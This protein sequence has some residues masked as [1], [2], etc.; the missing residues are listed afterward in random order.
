MSKPGGLAQKLMEKTTNKTMSKPGSLTAAA[1]QTI[2]PGSFASTLAKSGL[3]LLRGHT[4][5]L[6]INM[7]LLCNQMCRHCHLEAGPGRSETMDAKT[8]AD[9]IGFAGGGGFQTIDITG[10]APELNSNLT[11]L[12]ER[13]ATLAPRIML[14]CN[15][16]ALTD[17]RRHLL[18][19]C[20]EYKV[21]L[22]A[23]FPSLN[24]GQADSQRGAGTWQRSIAAL[25][26]LNA[27]GYGE[28]GSGLELDIV[29]NPAGAF[30][31]S[32]Q[33]A[34]EKKFRRDLGA[35]WGI[36]FNH[37]YTFGNVPLGRFRKWLTE[38]GNFEA[39]MRRLTECFNPC[40]IPGLMCRTLVSVSWD[41]YLYDCDFNLAQS[42]PLGGRQTHVSEAEGP[43]APGTVI[44]VG[45]HCYACTAGPGFT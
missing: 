19:L 40:T 9:V 38:S 13:L 39:Y 25:K 6:Q 28:P 14:R 32:S 44:G 15:L 8:A 41:G 1:E 16:T 21:V 26:E 18:E 2:L 3:E 10:G 23:S 29:S 43:P 27:A 31:P 5:V 30:L 45:D 12:I 7:G 24:Q 11:T 20:R 4:T 34:T 22:V 17:G 33:E 42:I 36:K 37:L 35:R